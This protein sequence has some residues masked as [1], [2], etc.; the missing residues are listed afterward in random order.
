MLSMAK[1]KKTPPISIDGGDNP[2]KPDMDLIHHDL[3]ELKSLGFKVSGIRVHKESLPSYAFAPPAK[4][5][6]HEWRQ[7]LELAG[8][9]VVSS[10]KPDKLGFSAQRRSVKGKGWT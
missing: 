2:A 8:F 7:S 4:K 10:L 6:M 3:D 9:E 5:A 1:S